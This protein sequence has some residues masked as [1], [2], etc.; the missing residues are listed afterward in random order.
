MEHIERFKY[1]DYTFSIFIGDDRTRWGVEGLSQHIEFSVNDVCL[2]TDDWGYEHFLNNINQTIIANDMCEV[3]DY[4]IYYNDDTEEALFTSFFNTT[5]FYFRTS[6]SDDSI[7]IDG[8]DYKKF[9]EWFRFSL[10]PLS[11]KRKNKI[12]KIKNRN[13]VT[14]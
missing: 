10:K 11:E 12:Q 6:L 2:H 8:D 14:S 1:K 5:S 9:M 4:V 3:K 13:N 7:K